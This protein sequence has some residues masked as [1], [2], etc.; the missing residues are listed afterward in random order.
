MSVK[1]KKSN[2][3]VKCFKELVFISFLLLIAYSKS[4]NIN[5]L[6]DMIVQ[7]KNRHSNKCLKRTSLRQSR[8]VQSACNPNDPS[9]LW[10]VSNIGDSKWIITSYKTGLAMDIRESYK[11]N[12][13]VLQLYSYT[14]DNNQ[15]WWINL[16][17]A[18]YYEM[19]SVDTSKCLD[20]YDWSTAN[21]AGVNTWDCHG[22][23]NQQFSFHQISVS[24]PSMFKQGATYKIRS[25]KSNKCLQYNG[26]N[27]NL[28]Q[29]SCDDDNNKRFRLYENNDG[30]YFIKPI[31]EVTEAT[32]VAAGL[33]ANGS[34]IV[35]WNFSRGNNQ[36][37]FLIA[38][39]DEDK[40]YIRDVNSGKCFDVPA[41]TMD[42]SYIQI[43]TCMD[44]NLNQ[45]WYF[46]QVSYIADFVPV[47]GKYYKIKQYDSNPS[48]CITNSKKKTNALI[49]SK[50][51]SND[52]SQLWTFTTNT[53][54]TYKITN[55]SENR[56]IEIWHSGIDSGD[57]VIIYDSHTGSTQKWLIRSFNTGTYSIVNA[58][59]RKCLQFAGEASQNLV[60]LAQVDCWDYPTQQFIFEQIDPVEFIKTDKAYK[61]FNSRTQKCLRYNGNQSA[62]TQGSCDGSDATKFA[63]TKSSYDAAYYIQPYYNM[64]QALDVSAYGTTDG[65]RLQTWSVNYSWNQKFYLFG[66]DTTNFYIRDANSDKCIDVPAGT[67]NDSYMHIWTCNDSDLNQSFTIEEFPILLSDYYDLD[68]YMQMYNVKSQ[69]CLSY[70]LTNVVSTV[71][72]NV[73]DESSFW[74]FIYNAAGD[75]YF[76]VNKINNRALDNFAFGLSNNNTIAGWQYN[77]YNN[78]KFKIQFEGASITS[79]TV[80]FFKSV[81]SS[82]CLKVFDGLTASFTKLVGYD[83][84]SNF[85]SEQF[86]LIGVSAVDFPT[87]NEYYSFK[88]VTSG[89]CL[90]YVGEGANAAE[91]SCDKYNTT[92]F[93]FVSDGLGAFRF[94]SSSN[95]N[96]ALYANGNDGAVVSSVVSAEAN[97]QKFFITAYSS[98]YF[99]VRHYNGRCL[100]YE[101]GVFVL[102]TC[103]TDDT[104]QAFEI[105]VALEQYENIFENGETC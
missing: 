79:S 17:T 92:R 85:F 7:I 96:Q 42:Y 11:L 33:T 62:I 22:G 32:D 86:K 13:G 99:L 75:Y 51:N 100:S 44:S 93:L 58:R 84:I 34:P 64:D 49:R 24:N 77:M 81:Q 102:R 26:H 18:D 10:F 6:D 69:K 59:S 94:V 23:N 97:A 8:V 105:S 50:C 52:N 63:F 90:K 31:N 61:I 38:A 68:G 71:P 48:L 82:K 76:I 30:S 91:Y 95:T 20:V 70:N 54:G 47:T 46:D 98:T 1:E 27:Q 39:Q 72:C 101:S 15:L 2:V 37:V 56:S 80:L 5:D 16:K 55:Y 41:G 89:Q 53:D 28:V 60:S 73:R 21:L 87:N 78:Q 29:N 104:K 35:F 45:Y 14:E 3:K 67:Y 65:T 43:W 9:S 4:D 66:H 36:K 103:N 25:A 57:P 74:K 40:Y 19:K 88:S 12:G 83:C